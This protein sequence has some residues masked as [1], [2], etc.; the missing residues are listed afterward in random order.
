MSKLI[1]NQQTIFSESK[2]VIQTKKV[3]V[4][5]FNET[6]RKVSRV[7]KYMLKYL[8]KSK[9]DKVKAYKVKYWEGNQYFGINCDSLVISASSR[10]E[11]MIKLRDYFNEHAK[12]PR[13]FDAFEDD[14][15][16]D[17]VC[18]YEDI[19]DPQDPKSIFAS[20]HID[21]I[22]KEFVECEFNNTS[23]W[24]EECELL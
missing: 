11:A 5:T 22:I 6:G 9:A 17:I 8:E 16:N 14:I 3:N 7:R 12:Y 21:D 10:L 24:L 20:E 4:M 23:L 18:E 2:S 19:E 13:P 1:K 15:F